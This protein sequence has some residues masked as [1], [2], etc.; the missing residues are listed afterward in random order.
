MAHTARRQFEYRPED[1]PEII[2][3][4]ALLTLDGGR[5]A[6]ILFKFDSKPRPH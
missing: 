3:S 6:D 4:K 1:Y 5:T 2:H